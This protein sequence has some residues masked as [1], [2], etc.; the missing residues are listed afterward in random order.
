MK[1]R[2]EYDVVVVGGGVTGYAAGILLARYGLHTAVVEG[3]PWEWWH[4]DPGDAPFHNHSGG[5]LFGVPGYQ[6]V[7]N[8]V[9]DLGLP[10]NNPG[11]DG[12][13]TLAALEPGLQTLLPRRWMNFF[14]DEQDLLRETDRIFPGAARDMAALRRK[15]FQHR[16]RMENYWPRRT[17]QA[18]QD[19][20]SSWG[21]LLDGWASLWSA[22]SSRSPSAGELIGSLGRKHPLA[23]CLE[24]LVFALTRR[25]PAET[26]QGEFLRALELV[27]VP[28]GLSN[29]TGQRG[30]LHGLKASFHRV[31]GITHRTRNLPL[32]SA[33]REREHVLTVDEKHEM[34]ARW[35]IMDLPA[36]EACS[37]LAREVPALHAA[38]RR[39]LHVTQEVPADS[40]PAGMGR[41]LAIDLDGA[42]PLLLTLAEAGQGSMVLEILAPPEGAGLPAEECAGRILGRVR[43]L[44]RFLPRDLPPPSVRGGFF[45]SCRGAPRLSERL[46]NP[47]PLMQSTSLLREKNIIFTGRGDSLGSSLNGAL[48]DGQ[49]LALWLTHHGNR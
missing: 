12:P 43:S 47:G 46:R 13:I 44:L 1:T 25:R 31:G 3:F 19:A 30:M 18:P 2:E 32:A 29:E 23:P 26:G 20:G 49:E 15:A 4:D 5:V 24:L 16:Q 22:I 14:Q 36:Q 8:L 41:H 11:G 21:R 7:T 48:A 34:R 45:P 39:A 35:L 38:E 42:G 6:P 40:I 28:S 17:G 27:G 10:L 9:L 37:I 33:G